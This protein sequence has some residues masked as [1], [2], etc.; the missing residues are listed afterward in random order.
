MFEYEWSHIAQI[1]TI[2]SGDSIS[3]TIFVERIEIDPITELET[4]T[5]LVVFYEPVINEEQRLEELPETV[6]VYDTG[7]EINISGDVNAQADFI[8]M[9]YSVDGESRTVDNI[10]DIPFGAKVHKLIP[11][12]EEYKYYMWRVFSN[13]AEDDNLLVERTFTLEVTIRWDSANI[14]IKK[15]ASEIQ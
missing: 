12:S 2:G 5:K 10:S 4:R 3:F 7:T 1:G 8:D 15:L 6:S 9:A 13:D 11:S 14:A